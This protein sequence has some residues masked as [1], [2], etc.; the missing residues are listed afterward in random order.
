MIVKF[1]G[2]LNPISEGVEVAILNH[3]KSKVT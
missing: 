2:D 3:Q 1:V